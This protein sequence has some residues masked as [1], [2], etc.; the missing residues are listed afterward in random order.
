VP[1]VA[2]KRGERALFEMIRRKEF[3]GCF[4]S[5]KKKNKAQLYT[6]FQN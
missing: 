1:A 5:W 6:F 3:V 2:V 4:L